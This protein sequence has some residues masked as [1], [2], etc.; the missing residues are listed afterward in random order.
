[1]SSM[2]NWQEL[3]G[4]GIYG[5]MQEKPYPVAAPA[6]VEAAA[7][8]LQECARAGWRVLPLGSG[9]SFPANFSLRSDRTFAITT[10]RLRDVSRTEFGRVFCQAGAPVNKVLLPESDVERKTIGGLL[11]GTGDGATRNA[12]RELWQ[13]TVRL[14]VADA[15]GRCNSLAGPASSNYALSHGSS[16]FVESRGK[17]GL[18]LGIEL[19]AAD[20][21]VELEQ[22]QLC[23][24]SEEQLPVAVSRQMSFRTCDTTSLFDW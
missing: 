8:I 5:L 13:R 10:S 14:V 20:L 3:F 21:P 4:D 18:V 23:T 7:E 17:A 11:C 6:T 15:R 22:R 24:A 16:L 1:M 12:A 9:S 19:D 2:A